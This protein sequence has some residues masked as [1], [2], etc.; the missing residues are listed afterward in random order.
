MDLVF[1]GR[2]IALN[3]YFLLHVNFFC[4]GVH[5]FKSLF[6]VGAIIGDRF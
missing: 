1:G 5:E 3:I 2:N 4:D 6:L